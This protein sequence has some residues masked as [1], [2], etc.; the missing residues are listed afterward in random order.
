MTILC[1]HRTTGRG[2]FHGVYVPSREAY[3][4]EVGEYVNRDKGFELY[5]IEVDP[6]ER[7]ELHYESNSGRRD[8]AAMSAAEYARLPV[9]P[10]DDMIRAYRSE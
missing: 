2:A 3:A 5:R 9:G 6:V 8:S 1:P 4:H 7:L 10:V